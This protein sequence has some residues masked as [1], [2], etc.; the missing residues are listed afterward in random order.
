MFRKIRIS[1]VVLLITGTLAAQN[2]GIKVHV[3]DNTTKQA[4]PFANVVVELGDKQVAGQATDPDGYAELKPLDPGKYNV[5]AV[6]SGYRDYII[7]GVAVS[8]DNITHLEIVMINVADTIKAVT[9]HGWKRQMVGEG[10]ITGGK[11]DSTEIHATAANNI[12]DIAGSVPGVYV[13]DVGGSANI[14]GQR[15]DGTQYII[16]GQKVTA[17]QGLGSVPIGI[18]DQINVITGGTPAKYGDVTG[19]IIEVNTLSGASHFFGSVQGLTSSLFD[20]YGYNDVNFSLGGPIWSKPDTSFHDGNK[21]TKPVLDFILGGDYT[22]KKDKD[23]SFT[24]TYFLNPTDMATMEANPLTLNPGGGFTRS[25]EYVTANQIVNQK[26]HN[27][28]AQSIYGINGKLNFHVTDNVKLTVGG[29]Y[30]FQTQHDWNGYYVYQMYNSAE[31]PLDKTTDYKLYGRLTQ[32]FNTAVSRDPKEKQPLISHAFYSIMAE[33]SHHYNE[34]E[35]TNFNQNYFDYGYIGNFYQYRTP[36]YT[37]KDGKKGNA[38][39][40]DSYSDSSLSFTPGSQNAIEANYTS[41]VYKGLGAWQVTSPNVVQSN[42]GLMNGDRPGNVYSL[43]Y[44]VGRA[45]P[46][47][48]AENNNH[49]RFSADFSAEI[50]NNSIEVGFEYEQN[51]ISQYEVVAAN[52]WTIMR[53]LANFQLSALDTNN[54]I[55][56]KS[57]STAYYNYNYL[58]NTG[59]QSQFDKSLREKI[60]ASSTQWIQPDNYTP[61]QYASWGGLG[62]FSA[63]DLLQGGGGTQAVFFTG[64]DYK[65]NLLNTNPSINDFFNQ[66]DA[67]GNLTYATGAYRPIYIAG[68]IQ[69]HFD[70]KSLRFDVGLRVDQ[71]NANEYELKD[72]YLLFPAKTVGELA[73]T[74]FAGEI[75]NNMGSN[76]V[77]YVNNSQSPTAIVGYRNG[78][79]W[80]NSTGNLVADPTVIASQTTSGSIQ[81][82]LE[83]PSQTQLSSNAFTTYSPKWNV[84]PRL[85]FSFPIND[86][87]NFFAHYDVL[88]QRPPGAA[89][90]T[91][92][93]VNLFQPTDYLFIQSKIGGVLSNPALVPQQTTDYELGFTQVLNKEKSMAVTFSAFYREFRDEIQTYRYLDAYPTSYIAYANLDF[94]TIK[95]LSIAYDLRRTGDVKFRASYNLQFATGTGSGPT[96]GFN[97][98][99]SGSPNLQIPQALSFDQRHTITATFDYHFSEGS[100]YDGPSITTHSGK[101]IDIL[102]NTG[103]NINFVAGSGT[104]Y[105]AW[106]NSTQQGLGIG[107]KY[108]LVG[109]ING[110]YLPW[111]NRIDVKADKTFKVTIKNHPCQVNVYIEATNVLNTEN[112][113]N[114]YNFTGSPTDDG[115]LSSAQG[116]Q[117]IAGQ[118]SPQSFIDQYTIQE[119]KPTYFSLP[120]QARLGLVFNF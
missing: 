54:P 59:A 98:A 35:N 53:Q 95:G 84:L 55:L 16:D 26:Y 78:N 93:G 38:Y 1:A 117:T 51:T 88:T 74:Q 14:R 72:P 66:R 46:A 108:S 5:K 58:P 24:G 80:Y 48:F 94:G 17:D 18:I 20:S 116:K 3:T 73:G 12:T 81:P 41:D 2:T 60:G 99:A 56:V 33:Y 82:Y 23:P 8:P 65:G 52:L 44:N 45:M 83:N 31:D 79:N 112:I 70:V 104:P 37:Y 9:V 15:D 106:S 86:M 42:L 76:Y 64:Y 91:S 107:G 111:Q 120:R 25:A 90:Y 50:A 13:K 29:S 43:W 34:V 75:P 67:N 47:F 22:Y 114:V 21:H 28:D 118:I 40:M 10:P 39:Y 103:V 57:G 92:A 69:D 11:A 63:S 6:Y 7:T 89:G 4:L 102:S 68:Y 71:F 113:L 101:K 19:G 62:M 27:N 119:K 110:V 109:S 85:A 49:F 105:T 61:S 32:K 36:H 100:D 30:Q 97:L 77:V 87:A 115:F 96:S